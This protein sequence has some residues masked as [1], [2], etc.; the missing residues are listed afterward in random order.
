MNKTVIEKS[1]YIEELQVSTENPELGGKTLPES[2]ETHSTRQWGLLPV[3]FFKTAESFYVFDPGR[4]VFLEVDE[5]VFKILSIQKLTKRSFGELVVDLPEHSED[6]IREALEGLEEIEAQGFLVPTHFERLNPYT[7]PEIKGHLN[8][9]LKGL[10]LNLTSKCN[11]ACSYCVYGGDYENHSH[12]KQEEMDW[13][14]AEKAIEFL[15]PKTYKD[16]PLRIDFFGGEPLLALPLMKRIVAELKEKMV[17]RNQELGFYVCTNGTVMNDKIID[18]LLENNFYIQISID[19]NRDLH[20]SKRKFRT[21][22]TGS[23]EKIMENLQALHDRDPEFFKTHVRLKSVITTDSL[24]SDGKGFLEIPLVRQLREGKQF[25]MINQSQQ[26]NLK[27]DGDFFD[28]IRNLG[29]TLLQKRDVST[30]EELVADFNFRKRGLFYSTFYEFFPIQV[31]NR[32]YFD[33]DEPVPFAKD[34]LI[35]IEGCVNVD[36]SISICYKSN[37]FIIGNVIEK[38]WYLDKIEEFHRKRYNR[39]K[40]CKNCFVQRFCRLCYE[41]ISNKDNGMEESLTNFC[42]FN[43]YYYRLIFGIMLQ[44]MDN[45]P[46]LWNE[47]QRLADEEEERIKRKEA[48]GEAKK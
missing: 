13:E 19:G 44:V 30:I 10:Y 6:A 8:G 14:T 42:E 38:T 46:N 18:F 27:K 15:L 25:T 24:D 17:S 33:L 43:R 9:S 5:L 39:S 28:R 12:L 7:L 36:G 4:S 22:H 48:E 16:G 45:N 29:E 23:F 31:H 20:N 2:F 37:T 26:Y 41:G 1:E 21:G 34:C 11:L 47:M 3:E 40:S 35:G 32:L